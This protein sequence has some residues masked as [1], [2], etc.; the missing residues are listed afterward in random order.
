[1]KRRN[2]II[3]TGLMSAANFA[4]KFVS[5]SRL[6][7]LA[8]HLTQAV[9]PKQ[10]D[11]PRI[12]TGLESQLEAFNIVMPVPARIIS[13][14]KRFKPGHDKFSIRNNPNTVIIFQCQETGLY[15]CID[16]T[17]YYDKHL[18]YG[19]KYE[20]MPIVNK[21]MPN[22]FVA[23]GTILVKSPNV[24]DGGIYSNTITAN[25]VNMALP[26]TIE[27][28]YVVSESF[29]QRGSLME[30]NKTVASWGRK[31]YPL[32]L[33]GDIDNYKPFPDVGDKIRPDGLVMALRSYDDKYNALEMDSKSLCEVD[34]IH[35]TRFY[36]P[37]NAIVYDV[38][39]ES[40]IGESKNR[41]VTPNSM[42]EQPERY[43]N[44]LREYYN[45]ILRSHD[46]ILRMNKNP[47]LSPRLIQLVTRAIADTPNTGKNKTTAGGI[48][49]RVYKRRPLDEYR[50]E[51]S[52]YRYNP[53][54]LGS[55][56]TGHNGD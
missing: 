9:S 31:S 33:Y 37:P 17:T 41:V 53:L 4:I 50:V 21:L 54:N 26:G 3:N 1:M 16:L 5:A 47:E 35:D 42:A 22:D 13:V 45:G 28:G 15:D 46:D 32:N 19:I 48:T 18:V 38:L 44:H 29:C 2:S 34:M 11:I 51:V 10:S 6:A 8:H 43:V 49:R 14:H 40:G 39:V 56:I 20:L 52:N 30:M 27:D 23:Q 7:M 36:G 12:L 25:V 55:K 24:K